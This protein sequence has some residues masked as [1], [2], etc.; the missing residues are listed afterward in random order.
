MAGSY[1]GI[2]WWGT[3]TTDNYLILR[4][5]D[6]LRFYRRGTSG[7]SAWDQMA[8]FDTAG[9]L[10][11]GAHPLYLG[12]GYGINGGGAASTYGSLELAGSKGGYAGINFS[13]SATTLMMNADRQGVYRDSLGGWLWQFQNGSLVT[14]SVP[15][16]RL[17]D[18]PAV[19]TFTNDAG[20]LTS[21]TGLALTGDQT[22]AG[23]K[24][25]SNPTTNT[26]TTGYAQYRLV[27][28]TNA[29]QLATS[30][31]GNSFLDGRFYIF[32][33]TH[34]ATRLVLTSGGKFGLGDVTSPA[35]LLT[36]HDDSAA[37]PGGGSWTN[38]SDS[39]LK[40]NIR[41]FIDGLDILRQINPVAYEYNGQ[42]NLPAGTTSIGVIAQDVKDLLPYSVGTY[43]AKAHPDDTEEMEF[44][45]FNASALPFI[46]INSI[47]DLEQQTVQPV[48]AS[49]VEPACDGDERGHTRFVKDD[50]AGD[51]VK[52]CG[53]AA[54]G[55]YSWK[56]VV[57]F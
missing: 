47:K 35:Y 20:Y 25:F 3:G 30:G 1:P 26:T 11:M 40:T 8:R 4:V 52:M 34:S 28:S 33:E 53:R 55:T 51:V 41:P 9:N 19:S 15:W 39:R 50:L 22:V 57:Q 54:D 45:N 56:V 49:D 17:I 42:A 46:L 2:S 23:L 5:P 36:L 24:T 31:S 18:I 7:G 6:G 10:V 43:K 13:D 37:K 12:A 44:Y 21:A 38:S 29:Y 32:D 14:G 48:Y 27:S 16:A